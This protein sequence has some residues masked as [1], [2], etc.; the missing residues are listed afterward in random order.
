M[1]AHRRVAWVKF[2]R[3]IQVGETL[4]ISSKGTLR[5][6]ERLPF[7]IPRKAAVAV[8]YGGI[9]IGLDTF[10]QRGASCSEVVVIQL[11][12]C[13]LDIFTAVALQCGRAPVGGIDVGFALYSGV[14]NPWPLLFSSCVHDF[15][16]HLVKETK[17]LEALHSHKM[18]QR[19]RVGAITAGRA[20]RGCVIWL[21]CKSDHRPCRGLHW[22][23]T[24]AWTLE[25][26]S[27]GIKQDYF[28]ARAGLLHY[29]D[30]QIRVERL[31]TDCFLVGPNIDRKKIVCAVELRTVAR[32]VEECDV[33]I[34]GL[35][36]EEADHPIRGRLVE[37]YQCAV[38]DKLEPELFQV[39]RYKPRIAPW[40]L[41]WRFVCVLII[42][43]DERD[44]LLGNDLIGRLLG[45]GL[46]GRHAD[47][48]N[49]K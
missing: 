22:N 35:G 17:N 25:R 37:I 24:A 47:E 49:C 14:R 48:C 42:A 18:G 43:D 39:R 7:K 32:E 16:G 30:D 38:A 19:L 26:A 41:Q 4:L 44:L 28:Q 40:I 15:E 46:I 20:L 11:F 31:K 1:A 5:V 36:P 27:A 8:R 33:G 45:N 9:P 34:L 29:F 10:C 12:I 21:G 23:E 3:L 2:Y 6:L 13:Q